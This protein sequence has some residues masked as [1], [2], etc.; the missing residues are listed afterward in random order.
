[1]VFDGVCFSVIHFCRVILYMDGIA[2][3]SQSSK[4][5]LWS[6]MVVYGCQLCFPS[7]YATIN[8]I[9]A[10]HHPH[11]DSQSFPLA[12]VFLL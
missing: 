6:F 9:S 12:K 4:A 3:S 5:F 8:N 11:Q 7:C 10:L 2:A 1:M